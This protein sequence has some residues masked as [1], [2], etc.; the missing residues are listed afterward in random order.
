MKPLLAF[1]FLLTTLNSALPQNSWVNVTD[2][3][4]DN[5]GKIKCTAVINHAIDSLAQLGGGTL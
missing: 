5:Q 4:A 3:G 1:C 2:K